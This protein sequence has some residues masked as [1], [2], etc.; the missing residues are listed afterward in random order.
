MN[1]NC[2]KCNYP[3]GKGGLDSYKG[4]Y[5]P[6]RKCDLCGFVETNHRILSAYQDL[7]KNIETR[8]RLEMHLDNMISAVHTRSEKDY[9]KLAELFVKHEDFTKNGEFSKEQIKTLIEVGEA[10]DNGRQ[11]GRVKNWSGPSDR[12]LI[13]R[14]LE[15]KVLVDRWN[16]VTTK[17][18]FNPQHEDIVIKHLTTYANAQGEDNYDGSYLWGADIVFHGAVPSD[19]ILMFSN[20]DRLSEV[21]NP[22]TDS[23]SDVFDDQIDNGRAVAVIPMPTNLQ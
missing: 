12:S 3:T 20:E 17:I 19:K 10:G 9:P 13:L 7:R 2:P 4:I 6:D 11:N 15:G 21:M 23:S 5:S 8:S 16:N 18:C 22:V 1:L 14:L